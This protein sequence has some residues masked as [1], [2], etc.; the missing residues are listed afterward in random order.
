MDIIH[1]IAMN[2]LEQLIASR[3]MTPPAVMNTLQEHG[4]ISDNAVHARNVAD[5]DFPKINAFLATPPPAGNAF[6]AD[7][8]TGNP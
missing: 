6:A 1:S 2:L 3:N 8:T 4:I 5:V 7:P